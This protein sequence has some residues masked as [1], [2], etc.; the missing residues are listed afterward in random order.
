MSHPRIASLIA[1]LAAL[2][3]ALPASATQVVHLDTRALVSGSS[4]IVI[5][6]IAGTR[7]FWNDRHTM[8]LTEVSVRISETLKGAPT[9]E[10]KLRQPGG[11]V[12]GMRYN[13]PGCPVFSRGQQALLFVWRDPS[14]RP[15]VNALAQGKFD[16]R[17]DPATGKRM[18][19]RSLPGLAVG[20]A[21]SLR[22]VPAGEAPPSI[23][24]DDMVHEIRTVLAEDRR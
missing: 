13:V 20:D 1:A 14:G 10:L 4:D 9:T 2:S 24:L 7:A 18:V 16:I 5:G 12:D 15:Q 3:A 23:P 22:A 19:Q 11:E 17:R 8:I 6:E 21:R